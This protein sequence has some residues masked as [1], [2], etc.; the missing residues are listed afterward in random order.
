MKRSILI[1]GLGTE[2]ELSKVTKLRTVSSGREMIILEQMSDGKW[3][4][5]YT[6]RTIPDIAKVEALRIVRED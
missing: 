4:L 2:L 5:T 3:R 6:E 1:E